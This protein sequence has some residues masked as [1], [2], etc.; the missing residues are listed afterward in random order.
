M[1]K[2]YILDTSV[3]IHDPN[4]FKTFKNNEV[5]IP[6]DVLNELDK[7]KTF[8]NEAGKNARVCIR[9]LDDASAKGAVHKGIKIENGITLKI[10]TSAVNDDFGT[11]GY[12]DNKILACAFAINQTNKKKK[13]PVETIL[14]SRDIN[15]RIRGRAAGLLSESYTKDGVPISDIYAGYKSIVSDEIGDVLDAQGF[16]N[17]S[18]YDELKDLFQNEC[19][20]IESSEGKGLGLARR[21]NDKLVAVKSQ[22]PW[23]VDLKSKEQA[24]AADLM[25][26]YKIPLTTI[27]G[28]AGT[29]KSLIALA[30]SL[31]LVLEKKKYR[32]LMIYRPNETIGQGHGYLPGTL[33]EKL[34]NLNL[35]IYDS[36]EFLF[37]NGTKND[38][39]KETI[40]LYQDKGII[41]FEAIAYLRGRSINNSIMLIDEAQNISK[42]DMKSILTR[43]GHNTKI[44][45]TGDIEQIDNKNLDAMDNGLSY[46]LEKFKNSK[47][48]G[49]ITFTKGERSDLAEEAANIL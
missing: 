6:I 21:I 22:K 18:I 39:W 46:V 28:C 19:L 1:K 3:L 24:F 33:D 14:V 16:V 15:L 2:T 17:C 25:L 43:A 49:H 10:D 32:K 29:G 13:V 27:I 9:Y 41:N 38:R 7:L 45:L 5:I 36:L 34:Y 31:E 8:P 30:C 23:N 42:S 40:E 20:Y 44:I 11:S 4:S 37:S 12:V 48:A 47:L 35:G 26:D